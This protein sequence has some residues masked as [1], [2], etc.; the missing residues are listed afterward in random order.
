MWSLITGIVSFWASKLRHNDNDFTPVT[1]AWQ[2]II[3]LA[4]SLVFLQQNP[5]RRRLTAQSDKSSLPDSPASA[6]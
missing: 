2:T 3:P 4:M 1:L 6:R 5:P